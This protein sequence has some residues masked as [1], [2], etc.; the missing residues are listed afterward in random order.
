MILLGTTQCLVSSYQQIRRA[1][2]QRGGFKQLVPGYLAPDIWTRHERQRFTQARFPD[3]V[4]L[5]P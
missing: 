4:P 5:P 1:T 3:S 2:Q